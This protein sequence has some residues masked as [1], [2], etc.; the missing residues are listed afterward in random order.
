M[1]QGVGS[2]RF[3]FASRELAAGGTR[4]GGEGAEGGEC[5]NTMMSV[6]KF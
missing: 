1:Q 6:E 3:Y 5:R 2:T 4:V